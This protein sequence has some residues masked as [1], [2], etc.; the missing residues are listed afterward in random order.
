MIYNTRCTQG[1]NLH[2]NVHSYIQ[3]QQSLFSDAY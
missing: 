1:E 3:S 2:Q